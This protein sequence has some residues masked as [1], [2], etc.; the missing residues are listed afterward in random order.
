MAIAIPTGEYR[1]A[2]GLSFTIR[3]N[4]CG[5]ALFCCRGATQPLRFLGYASFTIDWEW[6]SPTFELQQD[7]WTL[8]ENG[9]NCFRRVAESSAPRS[10]PA[11]EYHKLDG[12]GL[13]FD[14]ESGSGGAQTFTFGGA[15]QPLVPKGCGSFSISWEWGMPMFELQ[16][17]GVTLVENYEHRWRMRL[18]AAASLHQLIAFRDD[19]LLVLH[20]ALAA[21]SVRSAIRCTDVQATIMFDSITNLLMICLRGTRTAPHTQGT[22]HARR[23]HA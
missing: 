12:G 9:Q 22:A 4:G 16:D 18:P 5:E 1:K 21:A 14:I 17:D 11:G 8:V 15:T 10:I 7:G 2:D 20:R 3:D 6:G 23:Q 19:G 13:C